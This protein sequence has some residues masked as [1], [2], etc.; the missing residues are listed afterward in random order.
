ML[1]AAAPPVLDGIAPLVPRYDLFLCDVWGVVHNGKAAYPEAVDAL[2]RARAAGVTVVFISN[3]PRPGAVIEQQI[4]NYAVP[5]S[6]YDTIVGSGD[7]ARD[8][9][10]QR[11][12]A[13]LFHLG[14]E[15][16]LPNYQGLDLELVDLEQAELVVCTGLFDDTTET[17]DDYRDMLA[18]ICRRGLPFICA[19]P[20]IVVE[21]G[22]KLIWCAG[23]LAEAYE[24]MGG[25]AIFAGKPHGAIYDLALARTA[26]IRGR[27]VARARV[28]AIGDGV[29]TDLAG[30]VRHGFDCLFVA[31]GIHAAELDLDGANVPDASIFAEAGAWPAAIIRRLVW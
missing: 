3:A 28:L 10:R 16:D 7:V 19:N 24:K 11:P 4:A 2:E 1:S 12:G 23:A 5:R 31:G 9:L 30:A 22:D 27:P 25:K 6:C 15:R 8:E 29:R 21:R 17:P 26:E 14:P 20:D 13:K 18:E